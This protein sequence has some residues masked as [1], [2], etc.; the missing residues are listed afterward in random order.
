LIQ[1][2][3][4]SEY[5]W[6]IGVD[7]HGNIGNLDART[8]RLYWHTSQ[9]SDIGYYRLYRGFGQNM[10]PVI[11]DMRA[12]TSYEVTGE[13]TFHKFTIV[14][15]SLQMETAKLETQ[16][17]WNLFHC[18]STHWMHRQVFYFQTRL[19]M[20]MKMVHMFARDIRTRK[21]LLG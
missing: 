10:E 13:E 1:A 5:H 20:H 6:T 9:L 7:P 2:Y 11:E 12:Q 19:F 8:S 4:V 14:W 16:M 21:R 18:Q 15:S 17:G 3:Q